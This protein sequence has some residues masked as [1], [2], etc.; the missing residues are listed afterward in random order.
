MNPVLRFLYL[1]LPLTG[2]IFPRSTVTFNLRN[3]L[4][5]FFLHNLLLIVNPGHLSSLLCLC[6]HNRLR[7]NIHFLSISSLTSGPGCRIC[8]KLLPFLLGSYSASLYSEQQLQKKPHNADA[9]RVALSD[10]PFTSV[11]LWHRDVKLQAQAVFL[12]K[13]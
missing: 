6:N 11:S 13:L 3:A 12:P 7:S 2:S 9:S 5:C 1:P 4:L 8:Q 10:I